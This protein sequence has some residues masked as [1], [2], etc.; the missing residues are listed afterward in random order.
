[1]T[2][3]D[4]VHDIRERQLPIRFDQNHFFRSILEDLRERILEIRQRNL[5]VVDLQGGHVLTPVDELHFGWLQPGRWDQLHFEAC[6]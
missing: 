4:D 6:R 1:M 5:P 3:I 2:C